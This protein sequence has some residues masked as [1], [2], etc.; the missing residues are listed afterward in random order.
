MFYAV[1]NIRTM[2][3]KRFDGIEQLKTLARWL[4]EKY[5][6]ETTLLGSGDGLPNQS[7]LVTRY[8]SQA[9]MIEIDRQ[10]IQD[11]EF[12]AWLRNAQVMIQWDSAP[13]VTL[14]VVE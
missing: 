1:I 13:G 4:T 5:G 6:A 3:G 10:L 14:Q 11:A 9:Q 8:E 7:Q 12:T 2:P